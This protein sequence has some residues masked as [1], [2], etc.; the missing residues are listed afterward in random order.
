MLS[1]R[2]SALARLACPARRTHS[3]LSG[4]D[5][6]RHDL[7]A[8][9]RETAQPVAI[10]TALM[11]DAHRPSSADAAAHT[12]FHGATLSSFSS[13]AMD[14]AP[15]VA[16]SLRLP[17]RMAAALRAPPARLVV[18]VLAAAQAP[19][20]VRFSRPDLHPAPFAGV[21]HRLT[22]EGLPVLDGALGALSCVLVAPPWPLHDLPALL[23]GEH[24]GDVQWD[25]EGVA[26]ELF[27]ARVTRVE[28]VS[29]DPSKS[30]LLYHRRA[31]ATTIDLP[32]PVPPP[33]PNS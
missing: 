27:I 24:P 17:S 12:R 19:L 2:V 9:L 16:F 14:P 33:K 22:R 32:A 13:I 3:T 18:N 31:Y 26:S 30:P 6:V 28:K 11:P 29:E 20:A 25:G 5:A 8:L 7:R 1:R 15:L 23:R 21:P 4:D 10:V